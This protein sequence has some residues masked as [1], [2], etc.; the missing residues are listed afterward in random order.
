MTVTLSNS[1]NRPIT[2]IHAACDR[3][4]SGRSLDITDVEWGELAYSGTGATVQPD[5][6]REFLVAA[7]VRPIT[8]NWGFLRQDCDFSQSDEYLDG[9]PQDARAAK[10]TG[11]NGTTTGTL[12]TDTNGNGTV[13]TGE[14]L[15]EQLVRLTD[16]DSGHQFTARTDATG[17]VTLADAAGRYRMTILGP[18]ALVD[19][20]DTFNV[21][22]PPLD[23]DHWERQ[24][25]PC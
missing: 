23:S 17:V 5:Q 20:G 14:G 19:A 1:G 12:F 2:G 4:D 9:A 25:R 18:W 15:A 24:V 11:M 6:T 21:V 3:G 13:D 22:A 10:V 8:A 16:M 7:T